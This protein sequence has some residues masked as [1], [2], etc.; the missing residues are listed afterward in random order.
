MLT[1]HFHGALG[2]RFGHRFELDVPDVAAALR[3]LTPQLPGLRRF[4]EEH[5][6]RIVHGDL[7]RG[8]D[9]DLDTLTLPAAEAHLVPVVAGAGGGGGG[10]VKAVLG[11]AILAT[12]VVMSGGTLAAPLAGMSGTAF[13]VGGMAVS[14]GSVALFGF[15]LAAAGVSMML[16]KPAGADYESRE[17][18]RNSFIF[19]GA[20]NTSEQGSPVPVVYGRHMV[21]SKVVSSALVVDDIS[22]SNAAAG[23]WSNGY[24]DTAALSV[25]STGATDSGGVAATEWRIGVASGLSA[26]TDG[27]YY[28][29]SW[30]PRA[31]TGQEGATVLYTAATN[32]FS[33][34][35]YDYEG[36][37]LN[38]MPAVNAA[39]RFEK[40][41]YVD[42][43]DNNMALSGGV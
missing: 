12:A 4:V 29:A 23:D 26:F 41:V 14:Y 1:L 7:H 18:E 31:G 21:G 40:Y 17:D 10:A 28:V 37:S 30:M 34:L 24:V 36:F 3:L 35:R 15:A 27:A 13:T 22:V 38:R 8:L 39:V 16:A 5:W 20:V 33:F 32:R 43:S 2:E 42:V 11:T 19:N 6:F 25:T 9:L